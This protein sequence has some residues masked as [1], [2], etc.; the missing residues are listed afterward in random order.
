VLIGLGKYCGGLLPRFA[1][2]L[3]LEAISDDDERRD[4]EAVDDPAPAGPLAIAH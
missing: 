3:K 1:A 4:V 2:V